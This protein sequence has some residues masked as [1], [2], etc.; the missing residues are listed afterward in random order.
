LNQYFPTRTATVLNQ[1]KPKGGTPVS[2]LP[3]S[4]HMAVEW[5]AA[6]HSR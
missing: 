1:F 3:S 4:V 6:M 2:R 5:P